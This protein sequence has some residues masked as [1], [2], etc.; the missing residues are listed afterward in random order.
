LNK[1]YLGIAAAMLTGCASLQPVKGAPEV[2][3]FSPTENARVTVMPDGSRF[4][5]ISQGETAIATILLPPA[6][7]QVEASPVEAQP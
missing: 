3:A 6:P 4:V 7:V 5:V 1:K 2:H